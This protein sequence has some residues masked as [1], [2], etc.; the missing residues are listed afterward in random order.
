M[1]DK[2]TVVLLDEKSL[3]KVREFL[4]RCYGTRKGS[5]QRRAVPVQGR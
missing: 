4:L 1:S 5:Q 3:A 2:N